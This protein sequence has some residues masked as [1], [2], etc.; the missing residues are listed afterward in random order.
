[1]RDR[2]P[3]VMVLEGAGFRQEGRPHGR[4]P[5]DLLMQAQCSGRVPGGHRGARRIGRS[6]RADRADVGLR[7]DEPGRVD[8]HRRPAR[9]GGVT[10]RGR[11]QGR[12]R[13]PGRRRRERADPQRRA[14]RP[15]DARPRSPL[16]LVLPVVGV[17]VPAAYDS[18]DA[19]G[20]RHVPEL[21]EIIPRD[22]RRTYDMHAGDRR[23]VR[24]SVV[25]RGAARVREVGDLRARPA[26]R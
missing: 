15:G 13:R 23:G 21:L 5:T 10:G 3:L 18:D 2:F 17:V 20:P 16:P 12:A 8:L 14:R 9:R 4:S 7:G 24:R 19:L 26:R 25:V 1:M 11:H 6:R 22:G